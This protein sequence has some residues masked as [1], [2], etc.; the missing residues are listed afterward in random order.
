[1][2]F[3]SGLGSALA[4]PGTVSVTA[5]LSAIGTTRRVSLAASRIDEPRQLRLIRL[6][7]SYGSTRADG[8]NPSN[9]WK[10]DLNQKHPLHRKS[11]LTQWKL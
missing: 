8:V 9:H 4:R 10:R 7:I 3:G 2:E 1:M 11:H 6:W 5:R